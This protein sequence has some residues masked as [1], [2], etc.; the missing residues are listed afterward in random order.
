MT[1]L[2]TYNSSGIRGFTFISFI[3]LTMLLSLLSLSTA[4][5]LRPALLTSKSIKTNKQLE[6]LAIAIS[7]YKQHHNQTTPPTLNALLLKDAADALCSLESDHLSSNYGKLKGWCGPYLERTITD[8]Q[9]EYFIDAY[10]K[11][12]SYDGASIRSCGENQICGDS[13]DLFKTL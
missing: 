6:H 13:D 1:Y 2:L 12:F 10:G 11:A 4:L 7:N 5:L 9:S 3:T 8:T